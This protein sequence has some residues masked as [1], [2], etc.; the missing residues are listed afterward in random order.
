MVGKKE[1]SCRDSQVQYGYA[2]RRVSAGGDIFTF[3][4]VS[5]SPPCFFSFDVNLNSYVYH[6]HLV[7]KQIHIKLKVANHFPRIFP[8]SIPNFKLGN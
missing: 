1:S 2:E 6:L 4:A 5:S 8:N 3:S 7:Y